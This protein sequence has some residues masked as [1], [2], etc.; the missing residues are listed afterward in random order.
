MQAVRRSSNSLMWP[1]SR[2]SSVPKWMA[3]SKPSAAKL[4]RLKRVARLMVTPGCAVR[5]LPSRGASHR[6]PK[7]G[8]I[9]SESAPPPG[10]AANSMLPRW[11][12]SSAR[13]TSR[14]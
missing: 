7:A 13:V 1:A 11:M 8:R 3:A 14:P 9:A 6:V 5:N 4:K 10:L 2:Q 12:R